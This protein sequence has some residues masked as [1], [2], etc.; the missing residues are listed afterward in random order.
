MERHHEEQCQE[1]KEPAA[2]LQKNHDC[3]RLVVIATPQSHL[4][5]LTPPYRLS[6]RGRKFLATGTAKPSRRE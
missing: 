2:P 6:A 4:V 3:F 1:Q 5:R